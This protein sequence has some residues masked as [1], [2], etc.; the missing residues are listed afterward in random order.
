MR[1]PSIAFLVLA[2]FLVSTAARAEDAPPLETYFVVLKSAD[3]K[4]QNYVRNKHYDDYRLEEATEL[5][6]RHG[7]AIE[8]LYGFAPG[9]LVVRMTEAQ[10]AAVAA[11]AKV[12]SVVKN[13]PV[14]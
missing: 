1:R 14:I 6:Q 10:A 7:V 5:G 2:L 12:K 8:S 11:D 13:V 9:V 4:R 3:D